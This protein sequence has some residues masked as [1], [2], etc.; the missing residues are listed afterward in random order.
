[1]G[2]PVVKGVMMMYVRLNLTLC[3]ACVSFFPDITDRGTTCFSHHAIHFMRL[4][5][6]VI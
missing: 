4:P 6:K 3:R 1:M 5:K 2:S